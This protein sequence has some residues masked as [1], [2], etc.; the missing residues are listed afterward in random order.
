MSKAKK[1]RFC[2]HCGSE[3]VEGEVGDRLRMHCADEACGYVHWDN[4]TPVVAAIV[5]DDL[6][7]SFS[8]RSAFA[9]S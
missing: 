1:A 4:P 7:R 9:S 2:L 8:N 5:A 3:L 6:S